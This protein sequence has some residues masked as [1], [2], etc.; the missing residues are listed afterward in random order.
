[1]R[2]RAGE[3]EARKAGEGKEG[4]NEMVEEEMRRAGENI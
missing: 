1:V 3:E 4:R 2:V